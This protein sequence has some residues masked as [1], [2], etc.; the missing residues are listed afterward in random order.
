[1]RIGSDSGQTGVSAMT[2]RFATYPLP[3][4]ICL[5]SLRM[6]LYIGGL[7]LLVLRVSSS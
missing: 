5:T 3:G 7:R 6:S 2:I 4:P 1:M